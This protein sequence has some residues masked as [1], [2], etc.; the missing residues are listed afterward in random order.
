MA[1]LTLDYT[2]IGVYI[3]SLSVE[4]WLLMMIYNRTTPVDRYSV[5]G[6]NW[7]EEADSLVKDDSEMVRIKYRL[8]GQ[9]W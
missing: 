2:P 9:Y 1:Q 7:V 6:S 3:I 8:L 5:M 4:Q